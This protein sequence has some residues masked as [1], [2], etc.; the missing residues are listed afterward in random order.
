M[1]KCPKC[2][3]ENVQTERRP[4]GDS[5]CLTCG[6]KDATLIFDQPEKEIPEA[7]EYPLRALKRELFCGKD[8]ETK[9]LLECVEQIKN[10]KIESDLN[11][12]KVTELEAKMIKIIVKVS[13][14][15]D[16]VFRM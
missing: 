3:S 9:T 4:N 14:F 13:S 15:R 8:F 10:I 11:F 2:K 12:K 5:I 1:R 6:W 7:L 16:E